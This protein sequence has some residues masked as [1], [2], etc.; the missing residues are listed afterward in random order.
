MGDGSLP[1]RLERAP[2]VVREAHLP[3]QDSGQRGL[4]KFA[5]RTSNSHDWPC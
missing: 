1:G 4:D 5:E 3:P 2:I